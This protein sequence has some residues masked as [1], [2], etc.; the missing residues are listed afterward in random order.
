MAESMYGGG[1]GFE[2]TLSE[3]KSDVLPFTP[4]LYK[5]GVTPLCFSPL[6]R[7]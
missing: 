3:S 7:E 6:R 5:W 4:S 1:V 2:P